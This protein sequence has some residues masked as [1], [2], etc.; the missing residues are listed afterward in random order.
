MII[1]VFNI[2]LVSY[3]NS[4]EYASIFMLMLRNQVIKV[5]KQKREYCTG[6]HVMIVYSLTCRK[7]KQYYYLVH[8][9][10]VT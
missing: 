4:E 5:R 3:G 1:I 10:V 2:F 7:G 8:G 6:Q 9:L